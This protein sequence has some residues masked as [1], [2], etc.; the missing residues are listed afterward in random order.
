M[1]SIQYLIVCLSLSKKL[2]LTS[3]LANANFPRVDDD[4]EADDSLT[5]LNNKNVKNESGEPS[6]RNPPLQESS[7]ASSQKIAYNNK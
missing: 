6:I 4:C 3:S 7:S 1:R 5:L 2:D